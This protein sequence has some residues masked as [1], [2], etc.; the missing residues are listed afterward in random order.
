MKALPVH[1]LRL[2]RALT[3]SFVKHNRRS[4]LSSRGVFIMN[5]LPSYARLFVWLVMSFVCFE[6]NAIA[7]N[8]VLVIGIDGLRPDALAAAKTP[9]L[10]SLIQNG[11][12]SETTQIQ[13]KRYQDSD[14]ISGPGWS[15]ILTGVWA[16][17]H[18]VQD[19]SFAGKQYEDFPHYFVRIKEQFPEKQTASFIDWTPL[20]EHAVSG[21]DIRRKYNPAD[22][23]DYIRTDR[24]IATEASK[25]LRHEQID[26]AFVYFGQ[27]DESGHAHGFHPTVPE[28]IRAIETVDLHVGELQKAIRE[29]AARTK[30]NWLTLVS[31][32]HG[33]Q[34]TG[35][36]SGHSTPEILNVFLIVSG[37]NA[38]K[39]KLTQTTFIVDVPV[40][41][42]VYLGVKIDPQWKLDGQPIGL[43]GTP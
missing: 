12:F 1:H 40:T 22:G 35:H 10:D 15:S 19:N 36:G 27:V 20:D 30:E 8:Q 43:Q 37:K 39:G 26:A 18:G 9:N 32:D 25:V 28:Y 3:Y 16:D 13:G 21:A 17:K 29:R 23:K 7:G 33:G 31:S 38:V 6:T 42:L 34:G 5:Y 4:H 14:T 2:E 41:A 11:S 24:E